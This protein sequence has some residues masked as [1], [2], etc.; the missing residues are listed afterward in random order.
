MNNFKITFLALSRSLDVE[1]KSEGEIDEMVDDFIMVFAKD[2][3]Y[4]NFKI[5]I[6]SL[7]Q[8]TNDFR[9]KIDVVIQKYKTSEPKI[10]QINSYFKDLKENE[11][12]LFFP[13]SIISKDQSFQFYNYL[14]AK[15][16]NED[17]ETLANQIDNLFGVLRDK[18]EMLV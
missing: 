12:F 2:I 8:N 15:E 7:Q 1:I 13:N 18:Y 4:E 6:E 5:N 17:Y 14:S 11:Y 16:K 10:Q 9:S 3:D